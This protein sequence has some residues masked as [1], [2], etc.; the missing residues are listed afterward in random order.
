MKD[1]QE[2]L[3]TSHYLFPK[4]CFLFIISF[5]AKYKHIV[6]SGNVGTG[7]STL[8]KALAKR[9]GWRYISAGDFFREYSKKHNI[10]LWNKSKI[11]D[12]LDKKI[13]LEFLNKMKNE[14]HIVFDSH[15]GGW[16]AR[17]L[18]DVFKILLICNKEKATKR[19]IDREHTH[20]ETPEEIEKRRQQLRL[21]FKKLYSDENYEDPKIFN[22]V[23]DTGKSSIEET[24][25]KALEEISR[26]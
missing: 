2:N 20:K 25:Q 24:F 13:D 17:N 10:P 3:K 18:P 7:T 26:K 16:F 4:F 12:A 11:P 5:V 8:A 22:V 15:Y 23:I 21:K 14:N 19:I 6:V 9:L 1:N